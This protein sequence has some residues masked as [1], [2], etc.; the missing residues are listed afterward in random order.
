[1]MSDHSMGSFHSRGQDGGS[2]KSAGDLVN[3]LVGGVI[4][5]DK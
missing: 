4:G 5:V 1:M 3:T 2:F